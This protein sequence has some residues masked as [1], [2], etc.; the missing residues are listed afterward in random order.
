MVVLFLLSKCGLMFHEKIEEKSVQK[1]RKR[2][3]VIADMATGDE[4]DVV[5]R[6]L[7]EG[8]TEV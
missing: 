3:F 4:Y 6:N 2:N 5:L 1:D 8:I 7:P